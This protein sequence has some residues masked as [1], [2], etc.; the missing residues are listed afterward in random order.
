MK[1]ITKCIS[2]F[3]FILT[4]G[5]A[6][7][8]CPSVKLTYTFAKKTITESAKYCV[9]KKYNSLWDDLCIEAKCLQKLNLTE[10][11]I[12]ELKKGHQKGRGTLGF[13]VCHKLNGNPQII[14]VLL[15]KKWFT[16]DRCRL[17]VGTIDT[18]SILHKLSIRKN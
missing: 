7:A 17:E 8:A 18:E 6:V 13:H 3:L 2:L 11:N 9:D 5:L 14:K 10:A 16:F 1:A 4:C 15:D 12:E